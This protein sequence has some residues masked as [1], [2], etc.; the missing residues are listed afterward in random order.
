MFTELLPLLKERSLTMTVSMLK[1]SSDR[2]RVC[3][4]PKQ[5]EYKKPDIGY[6]QA[7][8]ALNEK[9]ECASKAL[10]TPL[11]ITGTAAEIDAELPK[12]LAEYT[13][14]IQGLQC[15]I[16]Q[17]RGE[18]ETAKKLLNEAKKSKG[19]TAPK[20]AEAK[21]PAPVAEKPETPSLG[22]FDAVPAEEASTQAPTSEVAAP[23]VP[24][25]AEPEP[26]P[27]EAVSAEDD[28]HEVLDTLFQRAPEQ[29]Q[30]EVA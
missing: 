27:V 30:Q 10:N 24:A 1:D 23:E 9:L 3:V 11:S 29:Q 14:K 6:D 20:A 17:V 13:E 8:T 5:R 28:A 18:L 22:L 15:D 19:K 2:L 21:A 7:A 26:L 16:D 12:A 25:P 4:V